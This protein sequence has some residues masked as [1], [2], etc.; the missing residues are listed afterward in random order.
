MMDPIDAEL[1]LAE[2][3]VR[4]SQAIDASSVPS[5]F[6][7][8]I[9]VLMVPFVAAVES[10]RPWLVALGSVAYAIG[11]SILI[12]MV[13][14]RARV[15]VRASLLGVRGFVAIFGFSAL[16]VGV[17]LGLGL[18]LETAGVPFPATLAT[19]PVAIGLAV[20]GPLLMG[21]LRRLM[22]SRPLAGSR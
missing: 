22:M 11:L 5:W 7:P 18:T 15:Q 20:G 1:A 17:G 2:V 21:F 16:M 10:E 13:V 6:W 9:G 12:V 4:R 14:R 8:S 19:I 3:R